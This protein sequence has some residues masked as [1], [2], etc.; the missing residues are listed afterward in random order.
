MYK[1]NWRCLKERGQ[2][3]KK[4]NQSVTFMVKPS[5]LTLRTPSSARSA[6]P[7][8]TGTVR[9]WPRVTIMSCVRSLRLL[10]AWF[11]LSAVRGQL[12]NSSKTKWQPSGL[13]SLSSENL[14][15][16]RPRQPPKLTVPARC[17]VK[18]ALRLTYIYCACALPC[19][20][21]LSPLRGLYLCLI[22]CL[23]SVIAYLQYGEAQN[24]CEYETS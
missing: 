21:C 1:I 17:R 7:I 16:G 10:S 2:R 23:L 5:A 18:V 4:L 19:E 6:N 14:A 12:F 24:T 11:V 20:I 3:A 13:N 22:E 15:P 9:V 8:C